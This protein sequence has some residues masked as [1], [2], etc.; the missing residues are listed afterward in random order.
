M[1][2][3][4]TAPSPAAS[5]SGATG[6]RTTVGVGFFRLVTAVAGKDLRIELRSREILYTMAFFAVTVVVVFSFAFIR[7]RN[8]ITEA[9]PG[10]VWGALAFAATLGLGRAFDREREGDT[11]RALLLSPAP[12]LAIFLG[13]A[14][15]MVAVIALVAVVIVPVAVLLY[16]LDV[17][18]RWGGLIAITALGVV[19][20]AVIGT[21][22]SAMLLRVRSRDVLLPVILYPILLP[23]FLAATRGTGALLAGD[24]NRDEAWFWMQ[25]LVVYDGLFIVAALWTFEALVIE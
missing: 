19:G 14:I 6:R 13:K 4:V 12:R 3:D 22:F 10:I 2:N 8:V 16:N 9:V 7:D 15:A 11:M 1:A 17:G 25:F 5:C 20:L 18:D 23:L 24:Q 21:V